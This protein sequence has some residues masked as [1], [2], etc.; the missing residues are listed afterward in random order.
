MKDI[1]LEIQKLAQIEYIVTERWYP[2][3]L[4]K[5]QIPREYFSMLSSLVFKQIDQNGGVG[6]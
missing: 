2:E 6:F 3:L 5:E 4:Y 1:R